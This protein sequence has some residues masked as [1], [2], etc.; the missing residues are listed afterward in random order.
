MKTEGLI[1]LQA[2]VGQKNATVISYLMHKLLAGL[3]EGAMDSD[4]VSMACKNLFAQI[5]LKG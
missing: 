3:A 5:E 4:G 2:H 1:K